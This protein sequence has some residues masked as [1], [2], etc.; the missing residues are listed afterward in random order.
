MAAFFGGA[1]SQS[2][3]ALTT[4]D[5]AL[6]FVIPQLNTYWGGVFAASGKEFHPPGYYHWYNRPTLQ[7]LR[8]PPSCDE[9]RG[10]DGW[11]WAG[12]WSGYS[13]NS[14]YCPIDQH[15]Y[16][17]Y[18]AWSTWLSEDD[19]KPVLVAAHE[20]GHHIQHLLVWPEQRRSTRKQ[21]AHYEL[22]ADCFAGN[23]YNYLYHQNQLDANDVAYAM[24]LL[25]DLGS[26]DSMMWY[27]P[28][29]HGNGQ[30]RMQWFRYGFD[31]P[32]W[33]GCASVYK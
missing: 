14:F 29:A 23:F 1:P 11:M 6:N 3:A 7:W 10:S 20:F 9:Y 26:P 18:T 24:Q 31:H 32:D 19:S 5:E 25:H 17:D 8:V 22:M 4:P 15:V 30:L 2:L 16:L 21:Y 28:H 12:R 13:P 33:A 27:E